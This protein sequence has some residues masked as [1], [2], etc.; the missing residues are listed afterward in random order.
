MKIYGGTLPPFEGAGSGYFAPDK[1]PVRQAVNAWIRSSGELD[2][3]VDFDA[4]VATPIG[5]AGYAPAT[6]TGTTST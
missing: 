3:V 6:T 1:E 4:A 5:R 2:G